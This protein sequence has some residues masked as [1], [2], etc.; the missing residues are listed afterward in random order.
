MSWS[1]ITRHSYDSPTRESG[2]RFG[3][4]EEDSC[5]GRMNELVRFLQLLR[6][7]EGVEE[8]ARRILITYRY[9]EAAMSKDKKS[10]SETDKPWT[11]PQPPDQKSPPKRDPERAYEGDKAQTS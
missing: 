9:N 6:A 1:F 8:K 2:S 11:A 10:S 5:L 7:A 4:S 3:T